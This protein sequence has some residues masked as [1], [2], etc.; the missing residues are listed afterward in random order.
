[1]LAAAEDGYPLAKRVT[2]QVLDGPLVRAA[3]IEGGVLLSVRGGDYELTVGQDLSVGYAAHDRHI[4]E[5]YLTES[6]TFRVLEPG[7]GVAVRADSAS[8][9]SA[10]KTRDLAGRVDAGVQRV[11]RNEQLA[12][13]LAVAVPPD[14][15]FEPRRRS[16]ASRAPPA[17]SA[18]LVVV[19]RRSLVADRRLDDR[20]SQAVRL[21]EHPVGRARAP[22]VLGARDLEVAQV[23]SVIDHPHLIGIAVDHADARH[24]G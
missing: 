7:G 23:V 24:L 16:P 12:L 13:R 18:Q 15:V 6:F 17:Y 14:L 20:Q 10:R 5:L 1:M 3:A 19:A 2:E 22:Q 21:L 9:R 11:A 4:V 8:R